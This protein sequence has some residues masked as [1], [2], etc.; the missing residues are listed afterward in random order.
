M[1]LTIK[2]T[3]TLLS[4]KDSFE[5]ENGTIMV[6]SLKSLFKSPSGDNTFTLYLSTQYPQV[7]DDYTGQKPNGVYMCGPTKTGNSVRIQLY[8]LTPHVGPII[9]IIKSKY[10]NAHRR[11]NTLKDVWDKS[12]HT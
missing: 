10:P 9:A 12:N 3:V 1:N 2:K 4:R 11:Y 6:P 8:P 7:V 5:T